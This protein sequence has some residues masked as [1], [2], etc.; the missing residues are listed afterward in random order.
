MAEQF[1]DVSAEATQISGK[2]LETET[3]FDELATGPGTFFV[4]SGKTL[5][6]VK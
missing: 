1:S 5:A 2:S 3:F 4:P 6:M